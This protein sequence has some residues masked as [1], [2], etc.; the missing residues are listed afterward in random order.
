MKKVI[1]LYQ[2]KQLILIITF[3]IIAVISSSWSLQKDGLGVGHDLN[4]LARINEMS[5]GLREGNLPVIWSQNFAYGYGMPLFQ[6]YAPLPYFIGAIAYLIGLDLVASVKLI[7]LLANILTI[8]GAYL[9]GKRL[10]DDYRA[11]V[12]IMVAITLAPYRAV[13]VFVRAAI[14]EAWAIGLMVWVMLGIVL[15]I[16]RSKSGWLI[17]SLSFSALILSH[18]LTALIALPFLVLF[19]L[20]ILAVYT[21]SFKDMIYPCLILIIS[22]FIGLGLA[23]FY[24]IP[25]LVE[26][27]FTQLDQYTLSGFYDFRQHFLY[28]RQFLKPWGPWEYG[29]SGWGPDDEMSYFLGFAQIIVICIAI[30]QMLDIS[31]RR[32]VQKIPLKSIQYLH[33]SLLVI[34]GISLFLTL[35]KMQKIWELFSFLAYIQ[36]PWRLLSISLIFGGLLFGSSYTLIPSKFK[37]FYLTMLVLILVS[38]NARYFQSEKYQDYSDVVAD[39]SLEVR[40]NDSRRL[41]D[42]IP[43]D[44]DIF[45]KEGFYLVKNPAHK[46]FDIPAQGLFE[47][48]FIKE[49]NPIIIKNQQTDKSFKV[50]V[51]NDQIVTLNLAY[52][53]G[54][55]IQLNQQ[56]FPVTP[57]KNGLIDIQLQKGN[58][59]VQL[60]LHDTPVRKISKIITL[61]TFLIIIIY[62]L[63]SNRS[64]KKSS[65]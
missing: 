34:T 36:F 48:G 11:A 8:A 24:F 25:A 47:S 32:L 9:L 41:Y 57:N 56:T 43:K 33:I 39:Y 27:S 50:S 18:N 28:I 54:W 30:I 22:F 58:N 51:A 64:S 65:L 42:F 26:K 12:L 60:Q 44:V 7:I 61:A 20:L 3:S 14:S 37:K 53:P 21:R 40:T 59:L 38:I 16:Q 19:A 2:H 46:Q 6:F 55:N 1:Q 13:D 15:V 63:A 45:T 29:G 4:H 52:Y 31:L 5:I 35:L 23:S 62:L 49:A 17:T 10:F